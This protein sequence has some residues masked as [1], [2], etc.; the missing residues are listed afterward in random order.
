MISC[1]LLSFTISILCFWTHQTSTNGTVA[2]KIKPWTVYYPDALSPC[3]KN[4]YKKNSRISFPAPIL[5]WQ[6]MN[7]WVVCDNHVATKT[8]FSSLIT[9]LYPISLTKTFS[10][11]WTFFS[12]QKTTLMERVAHQTIIL[13]FILQLGLQMKTDP[14]NCYVPFFKRF[15]T[16]QPDYLE[17]F[18]DELN[19]FKRRVKG[20]KL[21][22]VFVVC[23]CVAWYYDTY[24]CSVVLF[25]TD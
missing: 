7:E 21:G 11:N 3:N 18:N 1:E 15:E 8:L 5:T 19:S 25:F 24:M 2:M 20:S 23:C 12:R 6:D 13:Q 14:R 22:Y 16:M 9:L 10:C 17:S 4:P